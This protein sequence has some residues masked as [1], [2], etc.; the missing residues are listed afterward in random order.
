MKNSYIC[1]ILYMYY[2]TNIYKNICASVP[3]II[4]L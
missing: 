4:A 2:A 3:G 1:P